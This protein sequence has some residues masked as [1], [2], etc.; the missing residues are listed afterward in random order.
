MTAEQKHVALHPK[1]TV[2]ALPLCT[3]MV[4]VKKNKEE[5]VRGAVKRRPNVNTK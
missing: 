1:D 2:P 4:Q 3:V 5:K